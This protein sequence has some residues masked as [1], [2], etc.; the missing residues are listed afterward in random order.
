MQVIPTRIEGVEI[1][2]YDSEYSPFGLGDSKIARGFQ[3]AHGL[4]RQPRLAPESYG[5]RVVRCF[6]GELFVVAV[7]VHPD[8]STFGQWQ[9]FYL[10]GGDQRAVAIAPGIVRWQ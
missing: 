5:Q 9:C 7:D 10:R 1:I 8:S 6:E 2:R 4:T 3:D